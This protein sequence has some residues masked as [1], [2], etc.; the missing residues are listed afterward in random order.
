MTAKVNQDHFYFHF[1]KN[2][3][4]FFFFIYCLLLLLFL[5]NAI[6]DFYFCG[7]QA[8]QKENQTSTFC[9]EFLKKKN[10]NTHAH[11]YARFTSDLDLLRFYAL[12]K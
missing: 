3:V 7:T 8:Q 11:T 4:Y 2:A 5:L 12:E 1:S 9:I 6:W 10:S